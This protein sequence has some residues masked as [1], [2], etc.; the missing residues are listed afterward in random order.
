ML[1]LSPNVGAWWQ[2]SI[3]ASIIE[4]AIA[5]KESKIESYVRNSVPRQWLLLVIG[6]LKDS[7]YEVEETLK[8]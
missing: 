1:P 4:K 5:R 6:S 2:K 3:T 7:S 8:I